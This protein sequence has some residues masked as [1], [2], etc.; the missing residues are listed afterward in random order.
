[1]PEERRRPGPERPGPD[2]AGHLRQELLHQHRGEPGV[3]QLRPGTQVVAPG[4][5]HHGAHRRPVR[6]QP[7]RLLR[8]L[9]AVHDQH[10]EHQAG[11]G[12]VAGRGPHQLQKSQWKLIN[13]HGGEDQVR[14]L[15]F[16]TE[17]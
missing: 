12:P 6:W 11:H 14:V 3:P 16:V 7:G 5:G 8:E 15:Q 2:D 10:G 9:R 17:K 4:A 1:V 13:N